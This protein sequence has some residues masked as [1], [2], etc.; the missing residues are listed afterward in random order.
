MFL[1]VSVDSWFRES[2]K[3]FTQSPQFAKGKEFPGIDKHQA[4]LCDL[5]ADSFSKEK[6]VWD[7]PAALGRSDIASKAHF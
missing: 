1:K 7:N 5:F 3:M 4:S 2:N 6:I